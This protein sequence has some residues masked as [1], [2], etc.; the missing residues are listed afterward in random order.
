MKVINNRRRN[1]NFFVQK[2]PGDWRDEMVTLG[3]KPN[4]VF[5]SGSLSNPNLHYQLITEQLA[6]GT[7]KFGIK[8]YDDLNNISG[9]QEGSVAIADYRNFPRYIYGG[10]TGNTIKLTWLLPADGEPDN[11][12]IYSNNGSGDIDRTAPLH[13]IAGTLENYEFA[14][15][16]GN[17]QFIVEA[18]KDGVE[19]TNY[20]KVIV[21][22]PS[23]SISPPAINDPA[24][25]D[26]SIMAVNANTGKIRVS[27]I[28]PY[29]DVTKY[30]RLYHD[31][32]TGI[33]NYGSYTQFAKTSGF[34]QDFTTEQV[35][36]GVDNATYLFVIRA[37]SQDD[38]EETN[39]T[40]HQVELDG[41]APDD[42]TDLTLGSTF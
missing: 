1:N 17:W 21:D 22:T 10:A 16:D 5:L 31:D 34:L 25:S 41:V 38:V 12:L 15:A 13:V 32:G 42:V 23:S 39:T 2:F 6:E 33:I 4:V 26:L 14:V 27:F 19:S 8:T 40:E 3:T 36:F 30:F 37:V 9:T 7:H 28:Y 24:N 11:F 18:L 35:Y 29:G 20:F